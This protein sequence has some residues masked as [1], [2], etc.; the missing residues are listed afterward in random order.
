M[1]QRPP[2]PGIHGGESYSGTATAHRAVKL[3]EDGETRGKSRKGEFSVDVYNWKRE[4]ALDTFHTLVDQS[5]IV[6][7]ALFCV[8]Y[9]SMIISFSVIFWIIGQTTESAFLPDITFGTCA[10]CAWQSLTTVGY[11]T[12]TPHNF[13]ANLFAA[14]AVIVSI[15]MDAVIV[16]VL[17]QRLSR[18]SAKTSCIRHSRRAVI[19]NHDGKYRRF[20]CRVHHL[21]D[22][23]LV[24]PVVKLSMARWHSGQD[25]LS[26]VCIKF[27]D[28][29]PSNRTERAFLQLP[30]SVVHVID[31]DSPMFGLS[32]PDMMACDHIEIMLFIGGMTPSTGNGMEY[33]ASYCVNDIDFDHRFEDDIC[34]GNNGSL[35]FMEENFD[36]TVP[37]LPGEEA[38]E[39]QC[40]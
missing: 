35:C 3:I 28:L 21:S 11:G 33:R 30:W 27:A 5:L 36:V 34:L 18:A 15:I 40:S 37:E 22:H 1:E 9:V 7:V 24:E 39:L 32:T 14:A 23:A 13:L 31:E 17:Y 8:T 20:E 38:K 16:G 6:L 10:Q 4:L 19:S 2:A 25:G 29:T 26:R 12:T